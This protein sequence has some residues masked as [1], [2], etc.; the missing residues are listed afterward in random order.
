M[1]N[2]FSHH[3][4]FQSSRADLIWR[5]SR[6]VGM[7]AI[8]ACLLANSQFLLLRLLKPPLKKPPLTKSPLLKSLLLLPLWFTLAGATLTQAQ[9]KPGAPAVQ[10][11]QRET[12]YLDLQRKRVRARELRQQEKRLS[13]D[14]TELA[15]ERKRLN[16]QLIETAQDVQRSEEQLTDIEA[17]LREISSREALLQT[18]LRRQN[19]SIVSLLGAMQRMG[20]NPP[21]V[22]ITQRS[23][24]LRMVRSAMLLA[25]AFPEFKGKADALVANLKKLAIV[26]AERRAEQ[27]KRRVEVDRLKE[28]QTRLAALVETK[29]QTQLTKQNEI[30][31]IRRQAARIERDAAGLNDLIARLDRSIAR[32][33]ALGKYNRSLES[34]DTV[35][36]T[37]SKDVPT[38]PPSAA[39]TDAKI[40]SE[41]PDA[42][43]RKE[44][45][46]VAS[47]RPSTIGPSAVEMVPSGPGLSNNPGRLEPAIP[48][49]KARASLPLPAAGKKVINFGDSTVQGGKSKGL[50]MK[51]RRGAQITSPC[52]GWVVYAGAFRSY[53]QLLII[54]AGGGYHI[55]LANLSR[56]DVQLGQFV[57][58]SEPIG[59]MANAGRNGG[60]SSDPVLYVEFRKNGK[61][62]DPSPW[63][64]AGQNRVQG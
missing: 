43:R 42:K 28:K 22:I 27:T 6:P 55:L 61:P 41:K 4:I 18:D 39:K 47:L 23:D 24:A 11:K 62:I 19:R 45:T 56:L 10:Q 50:V 57:L 30:L 59:S 49:H 26:T 35:G 13:G 53:G 33:T 64:A 34:N 17:K 32:N 20:R 54:N 58:A 52:D 12:K 15:K 51:T 8:A 21:P 63:W 48:F 37:R 1:A 5:I 40:G 9:D 3:R 38:N 60:G 46:R 29:R 14:V 25:R 36:S 31:K 2:W 16:T 7:R 44:R